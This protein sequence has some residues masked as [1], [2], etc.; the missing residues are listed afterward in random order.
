MCIKCNEAEAAKTEGT[1]IALARIRIQPGVN[2]EEVINAQRKQQ[3]Q[4]MAIHHEN[5][6][7]LIVLN[8]HV[9]K[10]KPFST[11]EDVVV[12]GEKVARILFP[13]SDTFFHEYEVAV[14][15][16]AAALPTAAPQDKVKAISDLLGLVLIGIAEEDLAEVK[17]NIAAKFEEAI[18]AQVTKTTIAALDDLGL[19]RI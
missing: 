13:D 18:K 8:D 11:L 2:V 1:P 12:S 15:R 7:T 16:A 17:L 14:L 3:A 10:M 9:V 5:E 19:T 6:K 4:E